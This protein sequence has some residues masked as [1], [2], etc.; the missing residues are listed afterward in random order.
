MA[1]LYY[2]DCFLGHD[3][4]AETLREEEALQDAVHVTRVAEVDQA[5]EKGRHLG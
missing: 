5:W 2:D 4:I 1:L 3:T